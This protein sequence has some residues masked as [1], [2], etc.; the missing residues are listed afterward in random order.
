MMVLFY[1]EG[2]DGRHLSGGAYHAV[3]VD[4][5]SEVVPTWHPEKFKGKILWTHSYSNNYF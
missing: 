1:H 2:S 3:Q 4:A 5:T